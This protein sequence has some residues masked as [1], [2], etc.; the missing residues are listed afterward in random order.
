MKNSEKYEQH[1]VQRQQASFQLMNWQLELYECT[2]QTELLLKNWRRMLML[3]QQS[4]YGIFQF[5]NS[6]PLPPPASKAGTN[7]AGYAIFTLITYILTTTSSSSTNIFYF[8]L[9]NVIALD[10]WVEQLMVPKIL[11]WHRAPIQSW[12]I[13][14]QIT[15]A[16]TLLSYTAFTIRLSMLA[17]FWAFLPEHL[18]LEFRDTW[19]NIRIVFFK[20]H[21]KCCAGS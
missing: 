3:T 20:Q 13:N 18:S 15:I 11:M 6:F 10:K 2:I 14:I 5:H 12:N 7:N 19:S 16:F 4:V 8:G 21:R 1:I 9:D 17:F